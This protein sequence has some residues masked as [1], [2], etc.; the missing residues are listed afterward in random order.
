MTTHYPRF[1]SVVTQAEF[2]LAVYFIVSDTQDHVLQNDYVDVDYPI[3]NNHRS[4][5]FVYRTMRFMLDHGLPL[6]GRIDF[7]YY[8]LSSGASYPD[9]LTPACSTTPTRRSPR[10]G[11]RGRTPPPRRTTSWTP[12]SAASTARHSPPRPWRTAA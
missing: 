10:W 6:P 2:M 4:M 9:I 7:S 3:L 1:V 8:V 5:L 11:R 12:R